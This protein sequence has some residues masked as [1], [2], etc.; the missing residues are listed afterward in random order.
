VTFLNAQEGVTD[1]PSYNYT[2]TYSFVFRSDQANYRTFYA[3]EMSSH[4]TLGNLTP[5]DP[6]YQ[7]LFLKQHSVNGSGHITS[8][9]RVPLECGNARHSYLLEVLGGQD[10][11]TNHQ[12]SGMDHTGILSD[13]ELRTLAAVLDAGL[14]YTAR[15]SDLTAP[16]G[17][18]QGSPW[19]E[20]A[21]SDV[22]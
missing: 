3:N 7:N 8:M 21:S 6:G 16:E 14:P 18:N 11:D 2:P 4:K 20:P 22:R 9:G 12:F 1:T 19:G 15:C 13:E 5:W 17:P 10:R